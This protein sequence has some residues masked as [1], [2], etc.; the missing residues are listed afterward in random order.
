MDLLAAD[1]YPELISLIVIHSRWLAGWRALCWRYSQSIADHRV[2]QL[3]GLVC[4]SLSSGTDSH[5]QLHAL[6]KA[7][8]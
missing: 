5:E 6:Q 7:A 4:Q 8:W 1:M 2:L 3:G